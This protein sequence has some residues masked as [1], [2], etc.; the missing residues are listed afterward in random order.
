MITIK[1]AK[2]P[3]KI[4]AERKDLVGYDEAIAQA[5]DLANHPLARQWIALMPDFHI[6]YGMPIGGVVG[7]VGGVIPNAVGVDIGCGVLAARTNLKTSR[8]SR[9]KLEEIRLKIH[10]LIP[11]GFKHHGR[12]QNHP[13]LDTPTDDPVI[14]TQL[15]SA[16]KQIGTLGGGNHFIEV[17]AD[18]TGQVWL[19]IHSGSRNFGKQV[20][21]Y[22]H[23]I[24]LKYTEAKSN[25][26][27]RDLAYIPK[28]KPQYQMYLAAMNYCLHFAEASRQLML[29]RI[30]SA[31]AACGLPIKIEEQ[32]DI[33]HNFAALEKHHG[34]N[35]LVHRKGAVK[36]EGLLSIPGS[37][38]SASYICQ[39]FKPAESFN[40]CSHGAG[41]T[42]GRREAKRRFSHEEAV[43][44]MAKVVYHVR[45][46]Q[47]DELPMAY[48]DIDRVIKL[49]ADLAKPLHKLIPLAVVKG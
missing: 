14:K 48:K 25:L 23:K 15:A 36:A 41:R 46:G 34:Q 10:K 44:S 21:D 11:V 49:Q 35:L 4:W 32:F 45:H 12:R 43:K 40:S 37:M 17:Q 20:A 19:M 39:G 24:A 5:V 1:K 22:Y 27:S 28:S 31:F 29:D 16:D 18:E 7:T 8:L 42:I 38:G 13:Y 2:L 33:H 30:V 26:P 47:Y 6:G 3:L 9:P